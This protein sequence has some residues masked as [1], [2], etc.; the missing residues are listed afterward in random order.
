M[1]ISPDFWWIFQPGAHSLALTYMVLIGHHYFTAHL[2]S[3]GPEQGGGGV[4][5]GVQS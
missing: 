1:L 2:A 5:A 4:G 3:V